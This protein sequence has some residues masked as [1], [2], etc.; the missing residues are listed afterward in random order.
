MKPTIL[1][2]S[3]DPEFFLVFGHILAADG[4]DTQLIK[5]QA[6]AL[7]VAAQHGP[8]A[9]VVDCQLG[10]SMVLPVCTALK[11]DK[12]TR[13]LPM[14]VLIAPSAASL[15]LEL[16]KVGAEESFSRPFAPER[17]LVWLR[18]KLVGAAIS[19]ETDAGDLLH[20]DFR[21]E[22]RTHRVFFKD[23]EIAIPPIEF[24][25]L[26]H[27]MANPGTVFAREDLIKAAW[28]EHAIDADLRSV[29]VHIARL[30]KTL[31]S[32]LGHDVIRT[33][34]SAGYAFA[35]DWGRP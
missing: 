22:R 14:A 4:F 11:A 28:P 21:M 1:I 20:G 15:H 8:I 32:A 29:D 25:L 12:T 9:V 13:T 26:R 27:L 31:R 35:P 23:Q 24:K 10:D 17:L 3:Q 2:Y 19:S 16:I 34:R 30:R 7:R 6:D 5:D 18:S 33:V